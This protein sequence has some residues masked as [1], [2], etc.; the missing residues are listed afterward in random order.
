M[1]HAE[2]TQILDAFQRYTQAFQSLDARTVAQHY[3]EPAFFIT[4]NDVLA[5]PTKAAV[6]EVYARVM[7]SLPKDYARTEFGPL[8]VH[9]L[10]DDLAMVSGSGVWKTTSNQD[11]MPFGMTYTLRRS[12]PSWRIVVAA[13]H[14]ADGALAR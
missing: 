14:A 8:S 6:E 1:H 4:P 13:I 5:L 3:H 12:G 7:A 11:V 9:R 10:G 2:T